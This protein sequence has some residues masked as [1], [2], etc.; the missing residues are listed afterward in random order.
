MRYNREGDSQP[1]NTKELLGT[2]NCEAVE[3]QERYH[4]NLQKNVKGDGPDNS[5]Y[6]RDGSENNSRQSETVET[7]P[8]NN[9][10]AGGEVASEGGM[11]AY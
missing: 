9:S 11:E 8:E 5:L 4:E 6:Y 1:E 10:G 3:N 7:P 2:Q